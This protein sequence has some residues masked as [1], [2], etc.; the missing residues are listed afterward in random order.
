MSDEDVYKTILRISCDSTVSRCSDLT[1]L[2]AR[3]VCL[4]VSLSPSLCPVIVA[5]A[6]L[7]LNTGGE[8]C[9]RCEGRDCTTSINAVTSATVAAAGSVVLTLSRDTRVNAISTTVTS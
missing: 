7:W 5:G 4:S 8:L 6:M 2:Q 1:S 3:S 9:A